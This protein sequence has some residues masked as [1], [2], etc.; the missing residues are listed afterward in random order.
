MTG[1]K[2]IAVFHILITYT[3]RSLEYDKEF[4]EGDDEPIQISS[5][6]IT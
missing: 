4:N 5:A 1:G 6:D 3:I 2:N